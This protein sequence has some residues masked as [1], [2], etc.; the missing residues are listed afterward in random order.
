MTALLLTASLSLP[1]HNPNIR[2]LHRDY[3]V[4]FPTGNRNAAS[5]LWVRHILEA[6]PR[7][8]AE[9]VTELLGGFC[10]GTPR[11][12]HAP[13]RTTLTRDPRRRAAVSGSPVR[14]SDYHR[15]RLTLPTAAPGGGNVSALM[16]YCCWPCVCDVQDFVVADTK[17]VATA[18]GE[19]QLWW[20]VIGD[21]CVNPAK[22]H[23]PFTQPFDGR[24]TTLARDAPNVQCDESGKLRGAPRSD[25]GHV[26]IGP[27]FETQRIGVPTLPPP[28]DQQQPGK[29]AVDGASGVSYQDEHEYAAMCAERE[30]NGHNSGMGEIFRRVAAVA[31][32]KVAPDRLGVRWERVALPSPAAP[33]AGATVE[34]R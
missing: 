21:P 6:A 32:L 11:Y 23:E 18:D 29:I 19:R 5:H 28:Q 1:E 17:T 26:I 7:L 4:V 10:A 33:I 14:P 25:H 31:P 16:H 9:K 12:P 2:D 15:Y 24:E 34:L 13:T 22:L 3:S 8:P 27:L 20:A 30:R